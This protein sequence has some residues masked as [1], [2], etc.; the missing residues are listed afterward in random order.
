MAGYTPNRNGPM[1]VQ[2]NG[3]DLNKINEY[4]NQTVDMKK[5]KNDLEDHPKYRTQAKAIGQFNL[6]EAQYKRGP[7]NYHHHYHN[8]IV[9]MDDADGRYNAKWLDLGGLKSPQNHDLGGVTTGDFR[10]GQ[11]GLFCRITR[12]YNAVNIPELYM[13]A[14]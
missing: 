14:E 2:D 9:G 11:G 7:A 6:A 5:L 13:E 3:E 10:R 4:F 8:A 1:L 12:P